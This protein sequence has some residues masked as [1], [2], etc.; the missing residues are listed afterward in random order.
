MSFVYP[1]QPFYVISGFFPDQDLKLGSF[2]FS[3]GLD[4]NFV[5]KAYNTKAPQKGIDTLNIN[6]INLIK[7]LGEED[8]F[9]KTPC[10][11][12]I[13]DKSNL[14]YLLRECRVPG[15]SC[16]LGITGA[17][18]D[19]LNSNNFSDKMLVYEPH[20]IDN[21]TQAYSLLAIW[22]NWADIAFACVYN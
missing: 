6:S 17:D 20:N 10:E 21:R 1:N 18:L 19:R 22:L 5:L 16:T 8:P 12:L 15:N 14:T 2:N 13:D 9:I 7:S 11:L 3:I 4:K